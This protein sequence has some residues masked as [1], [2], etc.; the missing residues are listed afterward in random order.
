M[1][2]GVRFG[3]TNLIA[4]DWRRLARFYTELFGCVLVPPERNYSGSMLERGTGIPGAALEGAHLRL[5]GFGDHGPTLEIFT[6]S[7]SPER[8]PAAPNVLGFGHI[9]FQVDS[10]SGARD[11][12]IA[13]GG[14]AVGEVV[15]STTSAGTQVTWCYV[16]DPEGNIIELQS[17]GRPAASRE[18]ALATR[19]PRPG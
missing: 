10:V 13:A 12:V 11:Q 7:N 18:Q 3:H 8:T 5:P 9:A 6:Y 14:A 15:T 19:D 17:W 16:A 1:I 4:R 2:D